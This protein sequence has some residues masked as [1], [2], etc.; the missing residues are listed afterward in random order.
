MAGGACFFAGIF[1]RAALGALILLQ[2]SP[3]LYALRFALLSRFS[4]VGTCA[5][6]TS[7][8]FSAKVWM[9]HDLAEI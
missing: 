9:V 2:I 6:L 4:R 3:I 5:S 7:L 8:M 1:L